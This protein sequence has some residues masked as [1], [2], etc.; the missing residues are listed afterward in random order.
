[1]S[2]QLSKYNSPKELEQERLQ[3]QWQCALEERAIEVQI[4]ELEDR[5]LMLRHAWAHRGLL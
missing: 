2:E 3:Q 4:T 1:M 5:L